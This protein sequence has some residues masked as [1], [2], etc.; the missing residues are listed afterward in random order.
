M[1]YTDTGYRPLTSATNT[2][3]D[4]VKDPYAKST[5]DGKLGSGLVPEQT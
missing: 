4:P 1:Y 5:K 3:N 2:Q